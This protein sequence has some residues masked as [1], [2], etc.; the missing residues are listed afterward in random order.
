MLL[1]LSKV[2]FAS[3]FSSAIEPKVFFLPFAKSQAVP[4]FFQ[5]ID[6]L[7]ADLGRTKSDL[8]Q[9]KLDMGAAE[10]KLAVNARLLDAKSQWVGRG[11]PLSQHLSLGRRDYS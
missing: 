11:I 5:K 9:E 6:V 10:Q 7:T 1:K 4:L 3:T 8:L 2:K